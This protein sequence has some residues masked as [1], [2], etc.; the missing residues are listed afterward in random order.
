MNTRE[1]VDFDKWVKSELRYWKKFLVIHSRIVMK[2]EPKLTGT[3]T[4][5]QTIFDERQATIQYAPDLIKEAK[6]K[7]QLAILHELAHVLHREPDAPLYEYRIN[8]E[9]FKDAYDESCKSMEKMCD[10]LAV[11]IFK[12]DM[13]E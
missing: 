6:K 2:K 3:T 7:I 8:N 11:I 4:W 13:R 9:S 5:M 12:S 1:A 10:Q